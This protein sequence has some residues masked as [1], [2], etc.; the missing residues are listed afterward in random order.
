MTDS[1]EEEERK[2]GFLGIGV[3][4][5]EWQQK[6]TRSEFGFVKRLGRNALVFMSMSPFVF[7]MTYQ[8]ESHIKPEIFWTLLQEMPKEIMTY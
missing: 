1:R 7:N 8:K 4:S 5:C 3:I 2:R 6:S